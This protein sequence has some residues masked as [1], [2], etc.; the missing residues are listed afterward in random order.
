M[1]K[2]FFLLLC[3]VAAAP[4]A[5]QPA[6]LDGR[7]SRLEKEMRAVQRKVFPGGTPLQPE[8]VAPESPAAAAGVPA[9]TPLADLTA[10]VDA[11]ESQIRA[12]TAQAEQNGYRLR[13]LEE[14]IAQI[15]AAA[16]AAQAAA[17]PP[18]ANPST[19]AAAPVPG[20]ERPA[21]G[22]AAEDAYVY[23]FRLWEAKQYPQAQAELKAVAEKYPKHR[24]ASFAQNLLGRSYLDEGK[25][26]LASVAFYENYQKWPK[27]ERAPESLYWLGVALTQLKKP[28]EACKVYGELE[29]VYGATMPAALRPRIAEGRKQARCG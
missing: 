1:V 13:Q 23:G 4:L 27:G 9:T 24:R 6:E 18:A 5:A 12:I 21:T 29:D 14:R 20:V 22:D 15:E 26:A 25:P 10:R 8:I 7:V 28:A 16:Q 3:A 19:A 2:P 17:A 11:L